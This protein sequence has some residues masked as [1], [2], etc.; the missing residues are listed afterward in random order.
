MRKR[1]A[2]DIVLGHKPSARAEAPELYPGGVDAALEA[3][4]IVDGELLEHDLAPESTPEA[5]EAA[6]DGDR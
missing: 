5:G 1:H 3:P 2:H 6:R 4:P